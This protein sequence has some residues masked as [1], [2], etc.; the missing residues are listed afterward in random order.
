LN[1]LYGFILKNKF[2][3]YINQ[4]LSCPYCY[5][6]KKFHKLNRG[7]HATCQQRECILKHRSIVNKESSKKIDWE[8]SKEKAAKTCMEKYGA[9]HNWCKNTTSREK[10]YETMTKTYGVKYALQLK[11]FISQQ[12]K[13]VEERH[14]TTDF[15]HCEKSRQTIIEKFGVDINEYNIMSSKK[16]QENWKNTCMKLYGVDNP[17][18]NQEIFN[19]QQINGFKAK[20]FE[21]D[22]TLIYRGTYELHF[23][24]TYFSK[25]KIQ[26]GRSFKFIYN[27]KNK[28]YHSDYYIKSHNLV[29]EIKSKY[30]FEKYKKLNITKQKACIAQGYNF[31]FIIDKDYSELDKILG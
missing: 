18:K 23:L 14:G 29:I 3:Y 10:Y 6:P 26:N 5:K 21:K 25:I 17:M 22:N 7:Y 15:L 2:S 30:Y 24:E 20:R 4:I 16:V 27:R 12:Q 31:I 1:I 11:K 8:K 13:T 9:R 19:K 28:I